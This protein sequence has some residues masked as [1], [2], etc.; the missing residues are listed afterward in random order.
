MV[1]V[2]SFNR[3][4]MMAPKIRTKE[5]LV[6]SS[7]ACQFMLLQ[8]YFCELLLQQY[9]EPRFHIDTTSTSRARIRPWTR[10]LGV[11]RAHSGNDIILSVSSLV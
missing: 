2:Q 11:Q 10:V 9:R 8:I 1:N 4:K 3:K 7:L 5:Y 6:R